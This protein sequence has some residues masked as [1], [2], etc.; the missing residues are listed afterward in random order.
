M[1]KYLYIILLFFS[2]NKYK[3][4]LNYPIVFVDTGIIKGSRW[5]DYEKTIIIKDS[6]L[7]LQEIPIKRGY[8]DKWADSI[9]FNLK[10]GDTIR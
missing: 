6:L 7:G 4:D 5:S 9:Y 2:C 1:K 3:P 10:I 8:Y